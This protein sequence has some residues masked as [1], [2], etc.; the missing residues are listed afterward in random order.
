MFM[1]STPPIDPLD[2]T[3][4]EVA[5]PYLAGASAA[6]LRRTVV[7]ATATVSL[8][9]LLII[10]FLYYDQYERSLQAEAAQSMSRQ[11]TNNKRA[12][13]F[14][15]ME[16]RSALSFMVRDRSF[17]ELC[18]VGT[19]S[20]LM[21]H[22]NDTFALGSFADLG[23]ID[24]GGK[25]LCYSGPYDLKGRDYHDQDWFYRVSRRGVFVSDTFL[26]Y[27][28]S[29][30]FAIA[31]KHVRASGDYY[32]LRATI[33]AEVLAEQ[34]LTAG[35]SP[36]DD[37]FLVNKDGV[38][39][40]PSRRYGGVLQ[41]VPIPLPRAT[42]EVHVLEQADERH[43]SVVIA[44]VEIADSPFI[45][46]YIRPQIR[47]QGAGLSLPR[48]LLFLLVSIFFILVV[49]FWGSHQ[50]VANLRAHN[51]KRAELMHKV[52]YANKL[53]TIGRLAASV[54]HEINNP[55]AIINEK[56]GLLEDIV[57]LQSDFP[58][59]EK[60]L[61]IV[62]SIK[63]S[64]VRSR[65]ITH[66]LLGFAKRMDVGSEIIS[67]EELLKEVVSF[68]GKEV[69][70]RN[71]TVT[72]DAEPGVPNIE[73]D[74]GELQQVFLNLLNN[75]EAAVKDG[76]HIDIRVRA[77]GERR[78]A[79]SITD[80]G[81]GIPKENLE[82]IFEPFF[83]TKEG[84]GTGLGLSITYDIVQKL[85]GEIAVQSEVGNGACFTVLLPVRRG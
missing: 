26:G 19:L 60:V 24:S 84:S 55:L 81:I 48:L 20:L 69:E 17:A 50:F 9:P 6:R 54:A 23:L 34:I 43:R 46:V 35:L 16:R 85:G 31:I 52:E 12:L 39:Q 71:V 5:R 53:A 27:R 14:F 51:L 58:R 67:L 28:Q 33:N 11:V 25:Q 29:P 2:P 4:V 37:V 79:V 61:G 68:L 21:R 13:E 3:E 41:T 44:C 38:L 78:I 73:S 32:I 18:D 62:D 22:M 76:G 72:I 63:G 57:K 1:T 30:H 75:A 42:N 70:Y 82:R 36:D 15:L 7:L 8:L 66:R 10:S 40:S 56:A 59:R 49:I 64:V 65:T 74:R 83:T 77:T 47:P 80:D 45:L